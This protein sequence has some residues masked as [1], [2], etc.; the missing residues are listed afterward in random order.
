[1]ALKLIEGFKIIKLPLPLVSI[2]LPTYNR[3]A[4]L[5]NMLECLLTQTYENIEINIVDNCSTDERVHQ[6][7]EKFAQEHANVRYFRNPK[8]LGVLENATMALKYARG[9]YFCWVSDDDWR[10]EDFIKIC[11][12]KFLLE[13]DLGAVFCEYKE[14]DENGNLDLRYPKNHLK[15]YKLFSGPKSL[16]RRLAFYWANGNKGKGNIFY[17][18]FKTDFLRSFNLQEISGQYSY[19][20]M[21]CLLIYS[22]LQTK[23]IGFVGETLCALTC[24]NHKFYEPVSSKNISR[25]RI[26]QS[27]FS[28]L[29][30]DKASY[31]KNSP[32]FYEKALIHIL[33]P[34]KLASFFTS[35]LVKN[36]EIERRARQQLSLEC[37][38]VKKLS[39]PDITLVALATRN[40]EETIMALKYSY[41]NIQFGAIKLLAHYHPH[42]LPPEIKFHK[43]S[44]LKTIDDWSKMVVYDLGAYI[45]TKY[46]LLVHAD[47]FVVNPSKWKSEFL[48]YDYIG[49]PWPLPTDS[50]SYRDIYGNIIRVGNS[51]SLRSKKI[52]DL[53]KAIPIPWE[54]DSGFFN[55]DG[56]LCVKNKHLLEN[57]GIKFASIDIAKYFSH[58][59]PLPELSGLEPF[60]FHKWMGRN[61]RYPNFFQWI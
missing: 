21:D 56:F 8:N 1:M 15:G 20:N 35:L 4:E 61:K 13:P 53:P 47:G 26:I 32:K 16:I 41:K 25:L 46:A 51:V 57:Y 40:V 34:F 59:V 6:I 10:S 45:D 23:K 19:L 7:A 17:G 37:G 29:N 2:G 58:E 9:E 52:L 11:L 27:Y 28:E 24:G 50:Y 12:S 44:S 5:E 3:P 60:M 31:L 36:K 42:A 54:S 49:A 43:I 38:G 39:L 22:I 18:L 30:S 33:Y 48:D 14:V 55:E